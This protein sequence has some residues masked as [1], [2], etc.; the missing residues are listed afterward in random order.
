M[1]PYLRQVKTASG[2]TA[3][4]VVAKDHGVRRIVEHLG[5]AHDEA[6]LAALMRLGRQRLLAG[7]QVLD[8]GP[9]LN[10][11]AD[12]V[13]GQAPGDGGAVRRPQIISRRSA[14]LI[15]ALRS[16]YRRLGLGEAVGGD[17]AFEQMVAARLIEPTSKADTPR[18]LSEIGWPAPAHRNT[19]YASLG[20][21]VER[22][23]RQAISGAL[24]EHVTNTSGL[25]LCL[26]DVTTLYF[27]AEREDD[28]RRV[29]YS[30]ERRVDPQIIVGLLVDRAGFPL[31]VGCWE[32][33]KAETTTIIPVVE[34]FQAAH[35][36]ED[37]I[38]VADAGML[39]AA[40][41]KSLHEARLRF[42]VGAR[43]TRAP[44]DLEAHFHWEGDAFTDGQVID[45]ITPKR[46]SGSERDK[47]RKAEPVWDPH[48][49]PGSW[50]A[51]WSYSKKRAARDNQTL[52]TQANRAR[53]IRRRR[54]APQGHTFCHRPSR[55]SGPR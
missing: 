54:E 55:R 22:G 16:A 18:V 9:A 37:L 7:Q 39:S 35:G 1:S 24:F 28:L 45:T 26:Y 3:V 10:D 14:W 50:R 2:A 41:L 33:N 8:L 40:N 4:Q 34:A 27:E 12:E 52:T 47:S 49:H 46:G 11:D 25:A 20:R 6:E 23:Y 42:I 48:T 44:G 53:A 19:L 13:G 17:R 21:C 29:G 15:E 38:I 32:G 36:I 5:S 30:K 51:I 31:Q 43:T